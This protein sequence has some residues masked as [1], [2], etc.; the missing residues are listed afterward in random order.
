[1][2]ILI[3]EDDFTSR[4]VL[5]GVLR[6]MGHEVVEVVNGS[7]AWEAMRQPGAPQLAI[8]DWMMPELDGLEL[9][10]RI[11][12]MEFKAPPYLIMLTS[13]TEKEEII[14]GLEAGADDYLVKPF[15]PGELRARV[16]AGM[17]T[18]EMQAHLLEKDASLLQSAQELAEKNQALTEACGKALKADQAK[19]EFLANMSHEIR[20]PMNGVLGMAELLAGSTL[21]AEQRDWVSAI[22]RSGESLLSLLNDILDFSKIE[23]GQL[24]LESIPFNL[25]QLVFDVAELFRSR[26]EGR[27]VELLVDFDPFVPRRAMGDPGRLRQIL[28]NLVSNAIKFTE[29]GHILIEVRAALAPGGRWTCRLTVQDTGIGIPADKQR[30]L[31]SPFVQADSSTARRF[32][33]TGLGLTLVRRIAEAMGG[34]VELESQEGVGT[35]LAVAFP[36]APEASAAEVP[37]G[38]ANLAGKRIL[39]MDDLAINRKLQSRQLEACGAQVSTASS[40]IEALQ[41]IEEAFGRSEPF[42]AAV[43]DLHMPPGMDGATFGR[44]VRSDPRCAAMGLLVLTATRVRAEEE[45]LATI[46]FDGYLLKPIH[47][48]VLAQGLVAVIRRRAEGPS[49]AP[50]VTRYALHDTSQEAPESLPML[51]RRILLV[52]DQEVNQAV[53]RKFLEM[54]GAEV[55]VAGNG[56]I[57]L[58][59]L[60]ARTFDLVLMDCQ[61]P[62][63]D[64][65]EATELLRVRETSTGRR[66]PIVA[67]TAHAMAGDRDRCLAAGMDDYL[68]K[69]ITRASLLQTAARWLPKGAAPAAEP[70]VEPP[71]ETVV[72]RAIETP[73]QAAKPSSYPTPAPALELDEEQFE[74]IWQVF[75]RDGQEMRKIVIDPFLRRTEEILQALRKSATTGHPE[76]LKAPAHALKGSSLTLALRALGRVAARL[77][78]EGAT[79]SREAL[80]AWVEEAETAF[81]SARHFLVQIGAG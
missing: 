57:A 74:K 75:N 52:E 43:V 11:R 35:S 14:A 56:R 29:Q 32:G 41:L 81:A 73:V 3:A 30:L 72:E 34:G 17:R 21:S 71:V 23:A 46:G 55:A 63:M 65:F 76:E 33:G 24:R 58:D 9:C 15:D 60:A 39:V 6:K 19:S 13:K 61:M 66:L 18:L 62:E 8:L 45:R 22:N 69:P 47:R 78:R 50:L 53:A 68:T 36:L 38:E 79:A 44:M 1:M 27:P 26:L 42:D 51:H 54:A 37:A 28:N 67:M 49:K 12:A 40:G 48:D 4:A 77:E 2:R 64:G 5:A 20:T 59:M 70:V 80:V 10:R 25:E 16:K 7:Q 31:F